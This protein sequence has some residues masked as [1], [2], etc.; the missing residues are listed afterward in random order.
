[1]E[2]YARK[3]AALKNVTESEKLNDY[4][5]PAA[6][7][8]ILEPARGSVDER[9]WAD[10]VRALS[11]VFL[12]YPRVQDSAVSFDTAGNTFHFA[13]TEGSLVRV[14]E[15]VTSLR[16]RG[17]AQAPDGMMLRSGVLITAPEPAAMPAPAE[18]QRAVTEVAEDLTA[19]AGAPVGEAYVGPVLFAP[20][21]AGQ[22][23]AQVLGGN[24][25]VA[26]KP[27]SEPGRPIPVPPGELEGR[28]GARVMPEWM[29]VVDDPTQEEWRGAKLS[30]FYHVDME[31]VTPR[32][33]QIVEKGIL[34]NMLATKQPV[35]GI[36]AS[37]G[38]G[39]LPGPFG[40]FA[41]LIG[42]LFVRPSQT[43]SP[44]DLKK[45]LLEM[46]AQRGKPYGLLI[47]QLDFPSTASA[48]DLRRLAASQAGSG[49]AARMVSPP[50][51]VYRVYADGREELVR[52]LQFR[53][54]S[55]KCLRDIV[56]ASDESYVFNYVANTAPFSLM[57]AGGF[58]A[59]ASVITPALLIDDLELDRPQETLP[60]L[61]VVPPPGQGG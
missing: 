20:R 28:T 29:D 60:A 42:N 33:V 3:T 50:V 41:T 38:H 1:M 43:L 5:R 7:Q 32:P 13:N 26:R 49:A 57:D 16:V 30:G 10:R 39:R 46:C 21:A 51:L 6:V 36:D 4:S 61:P 18:L 45:R 22:F 34:K 52:G 27:V 55:A 54:L 8:L 17:T 59:G 25:G 9:Q 14:P 37:N 40:A 15:K 19:L 2:A 48:E 12:R 53:N 58:V 56:A 24:L 47:R 23:L 44:P 31:G 11:A 35:R